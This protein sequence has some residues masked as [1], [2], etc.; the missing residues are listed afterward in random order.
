MKKALIAAIILCMLAAFFWLRSGQD[1][2][3]SVR[4]EIGSGYPAAD[5]KLPPTK[6]QAPRAA[7]N[8]SA[9]LSLPAATRQAVKECWAKDIST[10]EELQRGFQGIAKGG[11]RELQWRVVR[12][13]EDGHEVRIRLSSEPRENGEARLE[14]KLFSVDEEGLPDAMPARPGQRE[15]PAGWLNDYLRGKPLL[16]DAQLEEITM[17]DGRTLSLET[18][19]SAVIEAQVQGR[20]ARGAK[21]L[22]CSRKDNDPRCQCL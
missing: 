17:P 15:N 12:T 22:A 10:W 3:A 7:P 19:N 9:E 13:E 20:G 21:A 4:E 11:H 16:S 5:P 1:N 14:I 8:V 2:P 6:L 18:E